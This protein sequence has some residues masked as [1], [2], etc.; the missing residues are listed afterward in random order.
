MSPPSPSNQGFL[1]E[2]VLKMMT[3]ENDSSPTFFERCG[4]LAGRGSCERE[5]VSVLVSVGTGPETARHLGGANRWK[6]NNTFREACPSDKNNEFF[7]RPTRAMSFFVKRIPDP[8][9]YV[10]G[11][12][13]PPALG[14][15]EV[16]PGRPT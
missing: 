8:V 5:G 14:R 4:G 7:A 6:H 15:E 1:G 13:A 11:T 3:C 10:L 12:E 2:D 9:A 16:I